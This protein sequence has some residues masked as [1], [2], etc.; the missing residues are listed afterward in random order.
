M[1]KKQFTAIGL[2][3]KKIAAATV[4]LLDELTQAVSDSLDEKYDK[5][6]GTVSGNMLVEGDFKLDIED[7]DYDAGVTFNRSLDNNLGIILSL[8]GY[9]GNTNYKPVL[10]NIATPS[11]NYDAATK[12]YVDDNVVVPT[13]HLVELN[14]DWSVKTKASTLTYASVS[15]NMTDPREADYLDVIMENGAGSN[16]FIRFHV[17]CVGID[18]VNSGN[19]IFHTSIFVNSTLVST[20]FSLSSQN[21][22]TTIAVIPT[23]ESVI[24]KVQSVVANA[25][26][27]SYYPSAKAVFDEF[28]RKPAV[29]W[30]TSGTG[31]TPSG[32]D[33][34][35]SPT[36][37]LTG[38]DMTPYKRIKIYTKSGRKSSGVG[39][40]ASFTP[41]VILEMSLD[42]RAAGPVG[43]HFV[44]SI[45]GQKPNDAN[46]M[47]SVTCAVSSDKTSF[48]VLR[49][50]SLY[51]TAATDNGDANGYVFK[52]EGYYD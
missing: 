40:D 32:Q 5:A 42:S 9:A 28:Q 8:G 20:T 4:D 29:V 36:W 44:A 49:M 30:E 26:S 10:R 18:E 43:N 23:P 25:T 31:L 51:G 34:T 37:Q 22:L 2:V 33:I 24:N 1:A 15:A 11:Q 47:F 41:G 52:I 46:R 7:E 19:L 13:Y 45:I 50:T 39:V 27:I 16:E 14:T 12:K 3:L 38:L 48:A 21:V 17:P 6:G 35:A